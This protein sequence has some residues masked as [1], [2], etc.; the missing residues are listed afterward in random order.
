M[1]SDTVKVAW[2]AGG[3]SVLVAIIAAIFSVIDGGK[4]LSS[5]SQDKQAI[6][7]VGIEL[8]LNKHLA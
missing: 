2:I 7:P 5:S 3:A 4:S 6:T 1:A 8:I